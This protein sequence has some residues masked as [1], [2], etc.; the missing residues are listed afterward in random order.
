MALVHIIFTAIFIV[1]Y[2]LDAFS[3]VQSPAQVNDK[4]AVSPAQ[5]YQNHSPISVKTIIETVLVTG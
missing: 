5:E 3:E 4:N 2:P 1:A